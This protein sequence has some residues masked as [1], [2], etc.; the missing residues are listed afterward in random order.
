MP[1]LLG[2]PVFIVYYSSTDI[3]LRPEVVLC[4]SA[5]S[6]EQEIH[7]LRGKSWLMMCREC[8]ENGLKGGHQANEMQRGVV[9]R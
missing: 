4:K 7:C 2:S 1:L 9:L 6:A 5:L 8:R 3:S